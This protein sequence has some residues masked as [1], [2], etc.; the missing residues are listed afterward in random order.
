MSNDQQGWPQPGPSPSGPGAP[1]PYGPGPGAS[2]QTPP[3]VGTPAGPAGPSSSAPTQGTPGSAGPG[4][5]QRTGWA[6]AAP[7][8]YSNPAAQQARP[9]Q[10]PPPPQYGSGQPGAGQLGPPPHGHPG[11]GMPPAPGAGMPPVPAGP[12]ERGH[13]QVPVLV[14]VLLVV[15]ALLAGTLL[16]GVGARYLFADDDTDADGPG[17][18]TVASGSVADVAEDVLSSTVYI[19]ATSGEDRT[20]EGAS[21]TG[22][23]LREDGYVVTNNHVIDLAVAN[24]TIIV[25]F[26]DGSEE[27]AR[28]IGRTSDYDLAVLHVEREGLEPLPLAD[29]NEVVV[30]DPV[31]AVG[32][33]LGLEGT[34]TTGIVSALN[35]PV[36]AG[37]GNDTTFINAIQTD[38]AINPGNSGG[39]LV[40]ADGEVIGINTAI[41]QA[42]TAGG[43]GG[44]IGLGF[45]T[46]SNQV[47]RTTDQII[48]DGRATYPVIGI[49][50]DTGYAGEG[51]QV[52]ED[53]SGGTP[54]VTPGGPGD[55]AGIEPGEVIVSIDGE[56]VTE[57]DELI[58]AVRA[59][60]PG[61]EVVLGVRRGN[62]VEE[63]TVVLDEEVSN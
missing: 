49:A 9:Q 17:G 16:G 31:V 28:V 20:G 3:G 32:A 38:A 15:V 46:P 37:S 55:E 29:S 59:R 21:G 51:V 18:G 14:T 47:R 5:D 1:G 39:P 53:E 2:G 10:G 7:G 42:A 34:V 58:V 48:E 62:G 44:S 36:T 45:A 11:Y 61:D 25:G 50:L 24:G 19:Q 63:V 56:P 12:P 41:A 26:P 13:R 54:P 8:G 23:V 22:L 35:R 27:E 33:P 60:A 6:P 52:L 40:N 4:A 57:P 30:G 43:A